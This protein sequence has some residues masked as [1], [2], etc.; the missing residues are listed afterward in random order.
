MYSEICGPGVECQP[1]L[2]PCSGAGPGLL[3]A[4]TLP[5]RISYL[6]EEGFLNPAFHQASIIGV[7]I[8]VQLGRDNWSAAR[9]RQA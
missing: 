8:L 7:V 6:P 2:I 4:V 9:R 5:K 1:A 3:I